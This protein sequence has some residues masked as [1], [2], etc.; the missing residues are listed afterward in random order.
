MKNKLNY[1]CSKTGKAEGILCSQRKLEKNQRTK[2]GATTAWGKKKKPLQ[3]VKKNINCICIHLP[4]Y[5]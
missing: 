4:P 5:S 1:E 3:T 2:K